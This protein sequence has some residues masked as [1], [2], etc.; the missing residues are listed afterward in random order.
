MELWNYGII[1]NN[2]R[3]INNSDDGIIRK[4]CI[5]LVR[6]SC[7]MEKMIKKLVGKRTNIVII[8]VLEL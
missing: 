7:K 2:Y 8:I 3:V 5:S 4:F 6:K 1:E